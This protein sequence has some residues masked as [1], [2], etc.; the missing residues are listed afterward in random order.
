MFEDITER[1]KKDADIE[2]K[3]LELDQ[4]KKMLEKK[5]N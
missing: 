1:K 3:L 5:G 2:A 4:L